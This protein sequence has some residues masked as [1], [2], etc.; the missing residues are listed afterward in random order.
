MAAS[1]SG[2]QQGRASGDRLDRAR[3]GVEGIDAPHPAGAGIALLM[4]AGHQVDRD[5]VRQQGDVGAG[6]RR[7]EQGRLDRPAGRVVNVNDAPVG[8][9]ALARQMPA[10]RTAVLSRVERHA[11]LR[12]P[13]DGGGRAADDVFHHLDVVQPCPR[14]HGVADM[15][16]EAVARLQHRRDP[17]LRPGGRALVQ[18]SLGQD[19]DGEVG[20]QVER[21]G[22][23]GRAGADDDDVEG[24]GHG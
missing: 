21:G 2:R 20:R 10:V 7:V 18:A 17:A 11:Q 13:L 23:P 5:P 12:Q 19:G 22:Q 4:P 24:A 9:A 8:V 1:T 15:R 14:D 16:L 3:A 6:S